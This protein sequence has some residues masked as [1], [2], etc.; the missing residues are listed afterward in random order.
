MDLSSWVGSLESNGTTQAFVFVFHNKVTGQMFNDGSLPIPETMREVSLHRIFTAGSHRE[1]GGNAPF[2]AH[3]PGWLSVLTKED[4]ASWQPLEQDAISA[5]PRYV[6][7]TGGV[8]TRSRN[9]A[10]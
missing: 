3:E 4:V 5:L 1:S 10:V 2:H 8:E 7:A 9:F 6:A